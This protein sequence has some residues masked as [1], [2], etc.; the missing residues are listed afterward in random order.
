MQGRVKLCRGGLSY[1]GEG[2]GL[3]YAGEGGRV[4]R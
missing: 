3:S 4:G 2:G 1:A